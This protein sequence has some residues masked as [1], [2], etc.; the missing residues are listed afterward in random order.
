MRELTCEEPFVHARDAT[1]S[2]IDATPDIADVPVT[3]DQPIEVQ[4]RW[5]RKAG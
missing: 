2:L 1:G 3:E 5:F 4:I